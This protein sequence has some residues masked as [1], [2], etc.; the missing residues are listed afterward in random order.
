MFEF[1]YYNSFSENVIT[2]SILHMRFFIHS[3]QINLQ[4]YNYTAY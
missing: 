4:I 2:F 1:E 3:T